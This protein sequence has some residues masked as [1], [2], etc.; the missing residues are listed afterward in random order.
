ILCGGVQLSVLHKRVHYALAVYSEFFTYSADFI[1]ERHFQSVERIAGVL[2]NFRLLK[3]EL[4]DRSL[5]LHFFPNLAQSSVG[6]ILMLADDDIGR[7]MKIA[8]G[9]TFTQKL[10]IEINFEAVAYRP[11]RHFLKNWNREPPC[12]ARRNCAAK[13][14]CVKSGVVAERCTDFLKHRFER[15]QIDITI[16]ARWCANADEG[17]I[18]TTDGFIDVVRHAQFAIADSGLHEF[19]QAGL[20]HRR[21]TLPEQVELLMIGVDPNHLMA[22]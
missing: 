20:S 22:A 7:R 2:K 11:P 6:E 14:N 5:E 16:A 8:N 21:N 17:E 1:G 18:R 19:R 3:L 10:R 13:N 4:D 15:G 12:G 9:R